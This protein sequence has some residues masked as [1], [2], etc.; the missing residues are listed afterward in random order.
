MYF[1]RSVW[2][3][4]IPLLAAM[5]LSSEAQTRSSTKTSKQTN[6][7]PAS[8]QPTPAQPAVWESWDTLKP[9]NEDFSI[10][11]PKDTSTEI[12]KFDYH[13]MEL[14][15]RL[16]MSAPATGPVVA[17]ASMSGIKSNPAAYSDFERFNSY[18]DAFKQF[19]PSKVRKD[20][21]T[22]MILTSTRQF[23]GYTGRIYKLT[24]GD[25]NG[26]VNAYVTKKRFYAIAVLNTKKDDA[27]EEKILSS[28]V[29]PDKPSEQ[30]I[31]AAETAEPNAIAQSE[32][33]EQV[34][35][36]RKPRVETEGNANNNGTTPTANANTTEDPV[37]ANNSQAQPGTPQKRAPISGGVLNG[38]AIYLPAPEMPPGEKP[39]V[40]MVQVLVDEQ[41][42]VIDAKAVS[43]PPNL[44]VSA[45]NAARL[46]RFL[47][48][49]L[50]GEPVKVSGTLAY[51]FVHS[52]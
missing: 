15:A 31:A 20:P 33:G 24:V 28:F 45:V 3:L 51:N 25:L 41:G 4:A 13:K 11:M 18:A 52:N 17:V 29:I 6:P 12:T 8:T 10:L 9:E 47:P 48:T 36:K 37:D 21:V 23:H 49:V 35:P 39:G 44:Q 50:S 38:K 2:L 7:A 30:K 42:S 19:F 26:T 5:S 16:Y 34:R 40:V 32:N 22:K 14:N 46:A 43:G 27:L 1:R